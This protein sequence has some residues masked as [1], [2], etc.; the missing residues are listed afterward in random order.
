MSTG[1]F[2]QGCD[3]FLIDFKHTKVHAVYSQ[4]QLDDAIRADRAKVIEG[5]RHYNLCNQ[6]NCDGECA[7]EVIAV[8][9]SL[10]IGDEK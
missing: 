3:E 9:N 5:I 4:P 7:D 6:P 8:I 2:C 10:P 1:N